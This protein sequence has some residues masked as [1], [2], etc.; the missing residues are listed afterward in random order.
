MSIN[1]AE[2]S[3]DTV[4]KYPSTEYLYSTLHVFN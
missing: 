4:Q 3:Q 1:D 2:S